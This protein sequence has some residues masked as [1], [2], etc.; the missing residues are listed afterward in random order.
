MTNNLSSSTQV[1]P[2]RHRHPRP[3]RRRSSAKSRLCQPAS[4]RWLSNPTT[5]SMQGVTQPL[6]APSASHFNTHNSVLL[7]SVG[8]YY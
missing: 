8:Y 4:E 7:G 1:T 2:Q 6:V 5:T 3:T